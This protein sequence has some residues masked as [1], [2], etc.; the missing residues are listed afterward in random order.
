MAGTLG[1][2]R[3]GRL[4]IGLAAAT[5]ISLILC[6]RC[7]D[8]ALTVVN[9]DA[10]L[11]LLTGRF[12]LLVGLSYLLFGTACGLLATFVSSLRACGR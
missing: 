5:V 4:R 8:Y 12:L 2:D 11:P 3:G 6:A 9:L 10:L 7:L 1:G